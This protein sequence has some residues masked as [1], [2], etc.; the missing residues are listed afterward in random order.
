MSSRL[1]GR[2]VAE[3]GRQLRAAGIET[4]GGDV[5]MLESM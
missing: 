3:D 5:R 4:F 2:G 1:E